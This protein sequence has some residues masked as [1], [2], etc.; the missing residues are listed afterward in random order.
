MAAPGG[1]LAEAARGLERGGEAGECGQGLLEEALAGFGEADAPGG[2]GQQG[3]AYPSLERPDR[4]ADRGRRKAEIVGGG[5]EAAPLGDTQESLD[6]VEL[7]AGDYI[8][9]LHGPS[10]L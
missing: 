2:P 6:S 10:I 1:P 3:H 7:V 9:L 8:F 5:A 4:L